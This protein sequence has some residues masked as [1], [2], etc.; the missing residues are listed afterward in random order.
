VINSCRGCDANLTLTLVDLGVQPISNALLRSPEDFLIEKSYPLVVYVCD[1]CALVQLDNSLK[2]DLH[3]NENYTYFSSYSDSWLGHAKELAL[4]CVSDLKLSKECLVVELASNDGY[5]L[6]FFKEQGIPVLG[7]EPSENVAN[8]A[9]FERNIPTIVEFFG[10]ECAFKLRKNSVAADLI[11]A[12]NV[13]AHVPDIYDFLSGVEI[14]L[15]EE[16]RA[17]IEFPHLS[18]MLAEFQFD[19]IYH[20]HYSYLSLTALNPIIYQSGLKVIAVEKIETHGGSLRLQL[21]KAGSKFLEAQDLEEVLTEELAH[22]PRD[23]AIR[24]HF[25]ENVV[26]IIHDLSN[27]IAALNKVGKRI[28]GYGAAAKGNTILNL[29]GITPSDLHCVIDKNPFKQGKFLPGSHIPVYGVDELFENPPGAI[30]VLPWN[31]STEIYGQLRKT[32]VPAPI[33]RAVPKLEYLN[34]K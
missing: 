19:T 1:K 31:L 20:E 3:F 24:K 17:I 9:I 2:R 18:N 11:I 30:L 13:L 7:I 5:L 25:Q 14:L 10:R 12:I 29:A 27:E 26:R 23:P 21:A 6:Q 15:S 4:R 16:G 22:D 8:S 28:V 34:C 32:G 33:F